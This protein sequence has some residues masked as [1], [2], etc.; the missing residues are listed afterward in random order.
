[1]VAA[2]EAVR[3]GPGTASKVGTSGR[4][5][6]TGGGS[7]NLVTTRGVGPRLAWTR[8]VGIQVLG[9]GRSKRAASRIQQDDT[10]ERLAGVLERH[11]LPEHGQRPGF[12]D[13]IS[14]MGQNLDRLL[15]SLWISCGPHRPGP[16]ATVEPPCTS[17]EV[18]G[19]M[20][21]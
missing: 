18:Q 9:C 7:R 15:R 16:L 13:H 21:Q 6:W 1:M 2:L 20:Q 8:G 10:R 12:R 19:R 11:P 17:G 4:C 5:R 3:R 14:E